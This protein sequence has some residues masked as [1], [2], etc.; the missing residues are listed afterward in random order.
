MQ[1]PHNWLIYRVI[2]SELYPA[3]RTYAKGK[4]L[5][6]GCGKKPYKSVLIGLVD[7]HVGVD[8][9]DTL[10]NLNDVDI[11]GTAYSIPVDSNLFDTVICTDVI[12]HL[13]E[14]S[15]AIAE[16]HRVLKPG[17]IAI[18]TTPLF[19]HLHEQ[20]RDFYRYTKFGLQYLFEKNGFQIVSII[21]LGGFWITIG[22]E[23]SYYLWG[24]RMRLFGKLNPVNFLIYLTVHFVQAVSYVLNKIDRTTI[25]T[26]EYLVIAKK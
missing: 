19:W 11:I 2:H 4:L 25:F 15:D 23:T 14:P 20:P 13:E 6:I 26:T 3:F 18:Y 9:I 21:P 7:Q 12:E 8:H 1:S 5:D 22:Q 16:A 17:G 24:K 10:H